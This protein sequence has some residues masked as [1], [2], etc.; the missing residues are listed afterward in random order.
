MLEI[1]DQV[2]V[3]SSLDVR[4]PFQ[5]H[6]SLLSTCVLWKHRKARTKFWTRRDR[7]ISSAFLTAEVQGQKLLGPGYC[8]A[9]KWRSWP[10]RRHDSSEG[11]YLRRIMNT[12][13]GSE[14]WEPTSTLHRPPIL[15]AQGSV[16]EE[17]AF[18]TCLQTAETISGAC[19][20]SREIYARE[21]LTAHLYF[22]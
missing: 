5:N 21:K 14:C 18:P 15:S 9:L 22:N 7:A 1:F 12:K 2:S 13:N 19:P 17:L 3:A 10:R 6:P 16:L 11:D 8:R 4:T 20:E